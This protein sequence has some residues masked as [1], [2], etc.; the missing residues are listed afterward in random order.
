[1]RFLHPANHHEE[2][3]DEGSVLLTQI[4]WGLAQSQKKQ[5]VDAPYDR[6]A[7]ADA[8]SKLHFVLYS[9][10]HR[11]NVFDCICLTDRVK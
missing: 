4:R 2:W 8:D 10:P 7:H 5:K 11:G 1:M 3:Q 9:H 6:T